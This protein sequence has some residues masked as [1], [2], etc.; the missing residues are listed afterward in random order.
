MKD[1][2]IL[3]TRGFSDTGYGAKWSNGKTIGAHRWAWEQSKGDIPEG[4]MVLHK[5]DVKACV[6]INHLYLGTH[7]DNAQDAVQRG[8]MPTGNR[9][10]S[11]MHPERWP[12]GTH[13]PNAKLSPTQLTELRTLYKPKKWTLKELAVKYNTSIST[14]SRA[15]RGES[16]ADALIAALN[17][18]EPQGGDDD[19]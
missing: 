6:N 4:L 11:R 8:Q 14:I 19:R 5:C 10:G 16:Y 3:W 7:K 18:P 1:E 15:V 9:H 2:C 17:T 12:K 13:K